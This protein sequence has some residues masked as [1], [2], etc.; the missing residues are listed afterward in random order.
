MLFAALFAVVLRVLSGA[1]T[2]MGSEQIATYPI[3]AWVS[4]LVPVTVYEVFR[5]VGSHRRQTV[6]AIVR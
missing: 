5:V 3:F 1:A 2:V 6:D 4:A